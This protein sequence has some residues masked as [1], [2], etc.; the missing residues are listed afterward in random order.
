MM[1]RDQLGNVGGVFTPSIHARRHH[2][3]TVTV[4]MIVVNPGGQK[5]RAEAYPPS[6]RLLES[7]PRPIVDLR[8]K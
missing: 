4:R 6:L 7:T 8:P 3:A 1:M 2:V 5:K